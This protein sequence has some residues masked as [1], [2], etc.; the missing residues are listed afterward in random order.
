M[1]ISL[2]PPFTPETALAKMRAAEDAWNWHDPSRAEVSD[3]SY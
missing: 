1:T 3:A 2:R